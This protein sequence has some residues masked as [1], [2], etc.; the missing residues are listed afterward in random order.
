MGKPDIHS[1][2]WKNIIDR[3]VYVVSSV[4]IIMT[5]PQAAK[6]FVIKDATGVSLISWV[7]FSVSNIFAMMALSEY[8]LLTLTYL[9]AITIANI[10]LL[11]FCFFRRQFIPKPQP[12]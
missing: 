7:A 1:K 8:N 5:I 9:V 11:L 4:G 2:K 6:I 12:R 3:C 10:L